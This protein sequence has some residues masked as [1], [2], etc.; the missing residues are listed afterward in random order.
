MKKLLKEELQEIME[1]AQ[2]VQYATAE[3][4]AMRV[5]KG[6][7][8]KLRR[9]AEEGRLEL[10][11]QLADPDVRARVINWLMTEGLDYRAEGGRL[12]IR[13]A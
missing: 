4:E 6:L 7:D 3:Q 5:V 11:I 13:W 12:L 1:Q 8:R 9:A 10:V 2:A